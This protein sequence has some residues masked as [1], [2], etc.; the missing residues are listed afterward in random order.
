MTF[1]AE[2]LGK[3]FP[4]TASLMG[5]SLW[6][7]FLSRLPALLDEETLAKEF[8]DFISQNA[9]SSYARD[10][11]AVERERALVEAFPEPALPTSHIRVVNPSLRIV[12]IGFRGLPVLLNP[13]AEP[14]VQPEKGEEFVLAWRMPE[15]GEVHT[16]AASRED[17]LAL[18]IVAEDLDIRYLART[19]SA[20]IGA[21][22]DVLCRA[23]ERGLLVQ[24]CSKIQRDPGIFAQGVVT[25]E[26]YLVARGF[27]LQWH[28]TQACDL[29]CKHCYDRSDRAHMPYDQALRVLDDLY[30]FCNDKH[31]YGNVTFTGG[32]P[33]LYPY[34]FDLYKAASDYGFGLAILGN[35]VSSAALERI[36]AIRKPSHYQ[37][38]LEGLRERNDAVRGAGHFDR[39]LKFLSNLR[40]LG[41]DSMV[42]LTLTRDNIDDIIPLAMLLRD[43]TDTF[44]FNRLAMVGEGAHLLLPERQ[45]YKAFICD[46]LRAAEGN[47]VM[48]LKDN[49]LNIPLHRQGRPLFGGCAGF[50]CAAAFNFVALLPDGEVHA[51]RKLPSPIGNIYQSSFSEI[52]D[53][54]QAIRYRSGCSACASCPIRAVCGGCLAIAYGY[55]LDIFHERDPLCFMEEG[56]T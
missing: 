50:G 26:E 12:K 6:S 55:G 54:A 43:Y 5:K 48:G 37:I 49:F 18:K 29:H 4:A 25:D 34:F 35:P 13:G 39:S 38:S 27:T 9:C 40:S 53:S 28:I 30:A 24:P 45:K 17:L 41:I 33:F 1:K 8:A 31:V 11:F 44:H 2:S 23:A 51:C 15:T 21:L 16:E 3:Y 42:M 14:R 10:L 46:Y 22:A 56:G 47:P 52:Y 20:T 19:G 36:A 32:N 7:E